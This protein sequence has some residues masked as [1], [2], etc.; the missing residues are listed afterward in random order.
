MQMQFNVFTSRQRLYDMVQETR[1]IIFSKQHQPTDYLLND[2]EGYADPG[3]FVFLGDPGEFSESGVSFTNNSQMFLQNNNLYG[4][5]SFLS[6]QGAI[7]HI[8]QIVLPEA[9]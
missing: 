7:P 4:T 9:N 8:V 6:P 1:R 3:N 5:D 2:F